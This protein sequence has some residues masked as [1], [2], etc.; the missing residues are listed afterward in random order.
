MLLFSNHVVYLQDSHVK[1]VLIEKVN[2][3]DMLDFGYAQDCN[4]R[5]S[6]NHRDAGIL[7]PVKH[8]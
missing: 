5:H 4:E 1:A 3:V 6:V 7:F 2:C 8:C